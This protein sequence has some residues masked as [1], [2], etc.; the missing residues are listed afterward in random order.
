MNLVDGLIGVIGDSQFG[1]KADITV[2]V[3]LI[4]KKVG[5]KAVI[6]LEFSK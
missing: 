1:I 4:S 2:L 3:G 5:K 6:Y